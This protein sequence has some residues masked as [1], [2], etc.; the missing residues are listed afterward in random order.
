MKFHKPTVTK[1]DAVAIAKILSALS[2]AITIRTADGIATDALLPLATVRRLLVQLESSGQIS[3]S[4]WR[5]PEHP[6]KRFKL[7]TR[8]EELRY[9]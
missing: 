8:N 6:S 4:W 5:D 7:Y 3:M 9:G 1:A 2:G